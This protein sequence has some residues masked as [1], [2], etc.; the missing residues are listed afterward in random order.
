M[1][2]PDESPLLADALRRAAALLADA[3]VVDPAVDAELLTAH[4]LG[5]GRG[6]V[7]AAAI[8]GDRL[9]PQDAA[10]LDQLVGRRAAR[11]PLQH[12][13]GTAEFRHL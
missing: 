6:R 9:A 1:A 3:G 10:R 2:S 13:T 8:R 12:I 5:T 7:Q 4:V 11:E